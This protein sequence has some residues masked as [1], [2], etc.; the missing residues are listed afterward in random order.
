[1]CQN[2]IIY[3][4]IFTWQIYR[5]LPVDNMQYIRPVKTKDTA[6]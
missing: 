4:Q 3:D 5:E 2:N 1:M 6:T